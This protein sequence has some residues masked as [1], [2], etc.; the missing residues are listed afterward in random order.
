MTDDQKIRWA[1]L[2]SNPDVFN[3][4]L[5]KLGVKSNWVSFSVTV[6]IDSVCVGKY[7]SF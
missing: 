6:R 1:P 3:D 7:L 4:Y 2:E 5:L